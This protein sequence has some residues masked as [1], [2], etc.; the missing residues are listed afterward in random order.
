M[1][2]IKTTTRKN[3]QQVASFKDVLGRRVGTRIGMDRAAITTAEQMAWLANYYIELQ[4]EQLDATLGSD[5]QPM[6]PLKS[7][8][9]TRWSKKQQKWVEYGLAKPEYGYAGQKMRGGLQPKRDLWGPGEESTYYQKLSKK[10]QNLA[11]RW[12]LR[13]SRGTKKSLAAGHMRNDIRI[14]YVD[15]RMAK[16]SITTRASRIKA[17]A[18]E[19]KCPWWG[20]S[21]ASV[22]KFAV[23]QAGVFGGA[24]EDYLIN[25]GLI[26]AGNYMVGLA[27]RLN[28]LRG[29]PLF[30]GNRVQRAA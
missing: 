9:R 20:L 22:R 21:P 29:N 18:N 16:V 7:S 6:P 19:R 28:A 2:D 5:G 13:V 8:R 14:N 25:V 15:D 27:R 30:R 3:G 12:G 10:G 26:E 17:L 24:M 1:L 23:A 11:Q 4:Q